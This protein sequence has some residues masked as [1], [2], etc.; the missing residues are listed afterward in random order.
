MF[1][2]L[3]RFIGIDSSS[4]E[5]DKFEPIYGLSKRSLDDWLA[6]NPKL[7]DD[8]ERELTARLQRG[9]ALAAAG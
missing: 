7:K 2:S 9:R 6:R 1:Q 5:L 3:F 8:Y 4:T